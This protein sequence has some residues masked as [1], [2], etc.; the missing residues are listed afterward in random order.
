VAVS[1][2]NFLFLNCV[3]R[4]TRQFLYL[5]VAGSLVALQ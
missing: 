2:C 4:L 3:F 1:T 5:D